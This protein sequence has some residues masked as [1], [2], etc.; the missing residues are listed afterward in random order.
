[1]PKNKDQSLDDDKTNQTNDFLQ[2]KTPGVEK[3]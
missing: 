1:M 3:K 2:N